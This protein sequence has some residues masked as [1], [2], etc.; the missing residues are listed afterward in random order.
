MNRLLL[1]TVALVL[2]LASLATADRGRYRS[3]RHVP[4]RYDR[5]RYEASIR[6]ERGSRNY[7][8][9]YV[10]YGQDNYHRRPSYDRDY[11]RRID[12][13]GYYV[14]GR[15]V[16]S[17]WGISLGYSSHYGYAGDSVSLGFYYSNRPSVAYRYPGYSYRRAPDVYERRTVVYPDYDYCAPS[18][19]EVREY[20]TPHGYYQ[21]SSGWGYSYYGR[22]YYGR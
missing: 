17:N 7:E 9:T 15:A 20:Y 1:G 21:R 10:R 19:Y 16:R 13:G 3:D 2:G 6:Y 14:N 22:A 18:A 8:Q 4:D 11:V 5:Q 12:R